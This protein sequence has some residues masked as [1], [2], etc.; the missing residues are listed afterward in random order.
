M[1]DRLNFVER[2]NCP[3]NDAKNKQKRSQ[4]GGKKRNKKEED[5]GVESRIRSQTSGS[6]TISKEKISNK[7]EGCEIRR[8]EK[9]IDGERRKKNSKAK[10]NGRRDERMNEFDRSFRKEE[11]ER[12]GGHEACQ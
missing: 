1:D 12:I 6:D 10:R 9:G 8:R 4:A 5:A 11:K 3:P 2:Q 7:H